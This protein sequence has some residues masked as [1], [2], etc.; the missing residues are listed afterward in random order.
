[1]RL[2]AQCCNGLSGFHMMNGYEDKVNG[3]TLI[4]IDLG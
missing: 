3:A 2:I 4:H 1:M